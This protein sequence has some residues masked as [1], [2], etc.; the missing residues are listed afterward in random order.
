MRKILV[1]LLAAIAIVASLGV[2]SPVMAEGDICSSD[3]P[4]HLKE[5]AGCNTTE[6]AD[7]I[8]NNVIKV[9]L[10]AMGILAVGVMIFGGITFMT[11]NGD[12]GKVQKGKNI[13]IYG[14]V[15]LVIS[16]LAYAIVMFVSGA[17]SE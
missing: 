6:K 2:S 17:I 7:T 8:I 12:A 16:M 9:V 10:S 11:S 13:I 1:S 5:A 15:G 14:L 3:M 4:D